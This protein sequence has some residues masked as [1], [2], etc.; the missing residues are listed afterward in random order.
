MTKRYR[1]FIFLSGFILI[2]NL[3]VMNDL[4]ILWPGAESWLAWQG[5]AHEGGA[6]P[7][8]MVLGI[9]MGGEIPHFAMRLPGVI[10]ALL[11][12]MAYFL[13]SLRL[14]TRDML[15]DTLLVLGASLLFPN[16]A[17]I[18]AGDIWAMAT[19]WLAFAAMV[20][21]LKQPTWVWRLT[22]YGLLLP[23]VWVQPLQSMIFL[24]GSS[25]F[26]YFLHPQGRRLWGLNPW[27][28]GLAFAMALYF[29]GLLTFSQEA[30]LIGF[31]TGRFLLWNLIGVLPFL[32]FVAAGIWETARRLGQREEMALLNAAGLIFALLGHSLALPGILALVAARQMKNYFI[33]S[34]PYGPI[35]KAG[36]LLHL[37]IAFCVLT[38]LMVAGFFQFRAVGFRAMLATGGLYWML[39][40]IGV[41]GLFG[42]NRRYL[43]GGTILGGLLLT[44]M[45]WL[46]ANPLLQKQLDWPKRLVELSRRETKEKE[47]VHAYLVHRR[48]E[49]FPPLAPYCK[50]AYR[51][52]RILEGEERLQEAWE[53]ASDAVF[54]LKLSDADVL[55]PI[56]LPADTLQGWDTRLRAVEYVLLVK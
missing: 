14:F 42:P 17:K 8:E 38:P 34:Y 7:P 48:G 31:R 44:S 10:I 25:A 27:A 22:F 29:S 47:A 24:L 40:F 55:K 23:A 20:R 43:Y 39:S 54:M 3:L 49:A 53:E 37:V 50:A 5:L 21:Y 52:T 45:F 1:F 11:A 2:A 16:L 26:L 51:Q 32:G 13:I 30:F 4:T 6:F 36:A 12:M 33:P 41:I 9:V 28:V 15:W 35:V 18:A 19:Q 56:S 46:Q